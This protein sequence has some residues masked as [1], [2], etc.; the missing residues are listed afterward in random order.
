VHRIREIRE[1]RTRG[2]GDIQRITPCGRAP[3]ID[4]KIRGTTP[5]KGMSQNRRNHP[6]QRAAHMRSSAD[7]GCGEIRKI[8]PCSPGD[9]GL[10]SQKAAE[11]PEDLEPVSP[12]QTAGGSPLR[13]AGRPR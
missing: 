3:K 12:G 11:Q 9:E 4:S 2:F 8:T 5:C 6:M 7:P 1:A 10:A 13:V